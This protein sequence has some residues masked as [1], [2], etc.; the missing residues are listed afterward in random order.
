MGDG[1]ETLI[2]DRS[3]PYS[4]RGPLADTAGM[5]VVDPFVAVRRCAWELLI[6]E[7]CGQTAFAA[8]DGLSGHSHID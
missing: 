2:Y 6:M 7:E 5:A 8:R 1:L 4:D 3:L